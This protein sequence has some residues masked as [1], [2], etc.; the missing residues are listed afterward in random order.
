MSE[1]DITLKRK[2]KEIITG[3]AVLFIK[4]TPDNK[5][6]QHINDKNSMPYSHD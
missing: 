1:I 5:T 4:N 6:L 3:D 2:R